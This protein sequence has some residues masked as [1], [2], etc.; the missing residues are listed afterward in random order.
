MLDTYTVILIALSAAFIA[1][2]I[3]IVVFMGYLRKILSIASFMAPNATIF[4]IGSK[5]TER[6][7]IE[8]LLEMTSITEVLSD[9]KKEGYEI[10][11]PK[12]GDVEIEKSMMA[13]MKEAASMMPEGV[14][15]FAEVYLLKF[16][17]N[18]VKR[19]LRA[20]SMGIAK[21]RIYDMIYEGN[22]ITKLII[23][24][25]VEAASMED[26]ITALDATPF[27]EVIPIWSETNSLFEV[28]LKLDSI[29]MEKIVEAKST[30]DEDS[31]EAIERFVSILIDV[32]NI[33]NIVRAKSFEVENVDKYIIEGGYELGDFKLRSMAEAR[34]MDELMANLDGTSYSFLRDLREPFD[35]EIALDRFLLEKANDLGLIYSTS[36]GPL[37]MFLVAKE[38]EARNLKAIIKGFAENVPKERIK[39]LLVGGAS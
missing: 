29:V 14:R 34:S 37:V 10:E 28:D 3:A 31:R 21:H 35:I 24:H 7:N 12:M 1:I 38:Y 16:D 2:L 4:A 23:N 11:D 19:I 8:R 5:Y 22:T 25:M 30:L 18:I 6:E 36:S 39:N 32:Q 15:Q 17:A 20:K 27:K 33:K 13:M 26:A 9:I